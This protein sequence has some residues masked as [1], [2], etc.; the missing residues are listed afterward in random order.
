MWGG[1]YDDEALMSELTRMKE[2]YAKSFT[3]NGNSPKKEVVFFADERGYSELFSSSPELAGIPLTN[4]KI[5]NTGVPFDVFMVEDADKVL[6]NY[7]AAIFVMP[8]P[9]EAGARAVALCRKLNIPYLTATVEENHLTVDKMREFLVECGVHLYAEKGEVVYLG[10]GYIALHS[11]VGGMKKLS[12]PRRCLVSPIYG[13][14]I[15]PALTDT[16]EFE[17]KEN[18]T[19]LFSISDEG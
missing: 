1:W 14:N 5:G 19:A 3:S 12:L 17:L 15:S 9:S 10:Q 18:G 8:I 6:K 2:I 11:S 13:A 4:T 16:V 7:K